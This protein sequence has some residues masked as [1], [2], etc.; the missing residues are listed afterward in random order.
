MRDLN[1]GAPQ[2]FLQCINIDCCSTYDVAEIL[3]RCPKC[4]DL[5]DVDY[6]W[7][8]LELPRNLS[9][10]EKYWTERYLPARFSG[11]WRFHSLLPYAP[12]ESVVTAGE[13]QTLLQ[14]SDLV[15]N[16]VGSSP[17]KLFLQYEGMNPSGSFKDN[18][19]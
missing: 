17:G 9:E 15:A 19:M 4:G 1:K 5:L 11:V 10:F 13:G 7:D 14:Q 3:T 6:A 18:G 12:L 2:A 8:K 16:Y